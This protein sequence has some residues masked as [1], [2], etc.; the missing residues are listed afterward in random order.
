MRPL[1]I[2]PVESEHPWLLGVA[3]LRGQPCPVIDLSTLLGQPSPASRWVSVRVPGAVDRTV[4]LAVSGVEGVTRLSRE[5]LE[6]T[7]PLLSMS[8][9]E[10][11]AAMAV[12]DRQLLSLLETGS[13]LDEELWSRL[14]SEL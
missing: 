8:R 7:P 3:V 2:E 10:A 1:A 11:V 4:A 9:S 14:E 5:T 6:A 12:H 13:L